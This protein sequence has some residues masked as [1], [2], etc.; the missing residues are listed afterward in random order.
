MNNENYLEK[1]KE[2]HTIF[3]DLN[4][5]ERQRESLKSLLSYS[6]GALN[7][8]RNKIAE[9]SQDIIHNEE[10]KK[11]KLSEA[12]S[13]LQKT[14]DNQFNAVKNRF[15]LAQQ[16]LQAATH[17][18][19]KDSNE[20]LLQ[21]MEAKEIRD[22]LRSLPPA[23]RTEYLFDSVEAGDAT[24]LRAVESQPLTSD[25]ISKDVMGK[26]RKAYNKKIAP[27][28]SEAVN[29]A[30]SDLEAAEKIR[31]LT[32]VALGFVERGV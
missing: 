4:L 15:A 21:F 24:V 31:N 3:N 32:L 5:D 17:Q 23:K 20:K 16:E 22:N 10:Y 28:Q 18:E 27:Q 7:S 29:L 1:L 19:P 9:L 8:L 26:A 6:F 30:K 12:K 13:E 14:L 2:S 11:E 25:L